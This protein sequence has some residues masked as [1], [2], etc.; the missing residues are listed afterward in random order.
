M[1]ATG[2]GCARIDHQCEQATGTG[3]GH[4]GIDERH[5]ISTGE[6]FVTSSTVLGQVSHNS[7]R[8]QERWVLAHS[9]QL[10]D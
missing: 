1:K 5:E 3:S 6:L 10:A 4:T 2:D 8:V 9:T 7:T